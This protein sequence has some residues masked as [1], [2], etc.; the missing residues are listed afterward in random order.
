MFSTD[1]LSLRDMIVNKQNHFVT[2]DRNR[3]PVETGGYSRSTPTAFSL[4]FMTLIKKTI[5]SIGK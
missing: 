1:S 4:K 5:H 2:N 3:P